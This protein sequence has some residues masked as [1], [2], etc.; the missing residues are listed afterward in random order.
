LLDSG[1]NRWR[2]IRRIESEID[3]YIEEDIKVGIGR[4]TE[5]GIDD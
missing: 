5:G 4:E 1:R 2:D 3:R